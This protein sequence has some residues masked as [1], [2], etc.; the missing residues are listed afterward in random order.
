MFAQQEIYTLSVDRMLSNDMAVEGTDYVG[1]I[2][3]GG[4]D[5]AIEIRDQAIMLFMYGAPNDNQ[6]FANFVHGYDAALFQEARTLTDGSGETVVISG[7]WHHVEF[8]CEPFFAPYVIHIRSANG[9]VRSLPYDISI[10]DTD[11][12]DNGRDIG[13]TI[14]AVDANDLIG[15]LRAATQTVLSGY[16]SCPTSSGHPRFAG[17][18]WRPKTDFSSPVYIDFSFDCPDGVTPKLETDEL[19][20]LLAAVEL[21]LAYAICSN[22]MTES[23]K[24]AVEDLLRN[25]ERLAGDQGAVITRVLEMLARSPVGMRDGHLVMRTSL[26][27]SETTT[28]DELANATNTPGFWLQMRKEDGGY[29]RAKFYLFDNAHR[30]PKIHPIV[31]RRQRT[32]IEDETLGCQYAS[33]WEDE[34]GYMFRRLAIGPVPTLSW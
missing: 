15:G 3:L 19:N 7:K 31:M 4:P 5:S 26:P 20:T 8:D 21:Q 1:Q 2:V 28:L 6:A 29:D 14:N 11:E 18:L 16:G 12:A 30:L 24:I 32:V 27:V 17:I 33:D 34:G 22:T 9:S 10:F 13:V 23:L 25:A